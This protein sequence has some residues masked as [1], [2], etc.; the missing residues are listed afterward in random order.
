[1]RPTNSENIL[2]NSPQGVIG[3]FE[4]G[5]MAHVLFNHI[6]L[7]VVLFDTQLHISDSNQAAGR[8]LYNTDNIARALDL[9]SPPNRQG[10][11]EEELT[12]ALQSSTSSTFENFSY[13]NDGHNSVLHIICTPLTCEN[14]GN[15]LG[16]ILLIEDVTSKMA[17]ENDL[18]AAERLA[19]VGKLAARVAHELNNPLDGI[20]RYINLALRVIE[21]ENVGQAENYLQESRKGLMRMVQIISELL[22]FSRS[23]FSAFEDADIN[24]IVEDAAK[25]MESQSLKNQVVINRNYSPQ[26]PNIRSGNLFQV[27]CNLVKNAIDAMPDGG[28]LDI[29]TTCDDHH[30]YILFADTGEGVEPDIVKYVFEPFFTTKEKGKGTGLGLPISKD[31]IERYSGKIELE[32]REAGGC[33]F[34]VS[35]PLE[36]TNRGSE[37]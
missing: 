12:A 31:I 27:F 14:S 6:P 33:A 22:E 2:S 5:S 28:T 4:L 11:W 13:S 29:T 32:N 36:R 10:N 16:G 34:R 3:A 37:E 8:V 20:L 23:T 15:L 25:A 24:K 30:A 18:A 26:M 7:G 35:I 19:A 17:M 9:G 21:N 1:M